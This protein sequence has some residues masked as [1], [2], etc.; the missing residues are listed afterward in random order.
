MSMSIYKITIRPLGRWRCSRYPRCARLHLRP[1]RS[2][3]PRSPIHFL[4]RNSPGRCQT[5]P[6]GI[7]YKRMDSCWHYITHTNDKAS[8]PVVILKHTVGIVPDLR[9][10]V[11]TLMSP[12]YLQL[13]DA[14][15]YGFD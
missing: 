5:P 14:L 12:N 7:S 15:S 13:R 6:C 2:T 9:V 4:P 1:P 11:G 10:D 8:Y 3:R